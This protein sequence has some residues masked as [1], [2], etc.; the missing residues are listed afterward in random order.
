MR[1]VCKLSHWCMIKT[2]TFYRRELNCV[3]VVKIKR[4]NKSQIV[5]LVV[6]AL[7]LISIPLTHRIQ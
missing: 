5:Y 6:Y 4:K 3:P 7:Y 2:D 1:V